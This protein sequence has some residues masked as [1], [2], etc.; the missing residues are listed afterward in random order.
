M[1]KSTLVL[2]LFCTP[3][4]ATPDWRYSLALADEALPKPEE[5]KAKLST[6]E[7]SFDSPFSNRYGSKEMRELFS[8]QTKHSTWRK[9]WVALAESEQE[10]GLPISNA[11]I[12]EM[13]A[14]IYTIDFALADKIEKDLK[15]DVMAHV[16]TYGVDCP[17]A[18]PIIHLGA[19]SCLITDNAE[20]IVMQDALTI[21]ERKL[22]TL[23]KTL[24]KQAD[25]YKDLP[26]LSYTH[27][28]AAQPTTVGKRYALWL[29]DFWLDW[30][31]LQYRQDTLRFLGVKGATGTQASFLELF[32]GNHE[33]VKALELLVAAKLGFS[34]IFAVSGQTY[35]RKQDIQ[36]LSI[37]SDIAVSAHKMA[38]DL[39]LLAHMKEIEEPFS[40]KQIGSSAMP[41]KRNPMENE[42]VCSL[43]RY[44]MALAENPKYTAAIQWL[45][46][47]LDDS[48]N[49]RLAIP[50]AF[51]AIDSILDSLIKIAGNSVVYPKIIEK[52]LQAELPFMA[53][54]N[55]LMACVKKGADRQAIHERLRQLSQLAGDQIKLEGKD[56]PL[57]EMIAN[58]PAIPLSEDE[59][60]E[61]ISDN[62]FIG[63][64]PQQVTEFL[65]EVVYPSLK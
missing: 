24:A 7:T 11:Q 14:H 22:L 18:R 62:C 65:D 41:Y 57:L 48:A 40:D 21:I 3:L 34:N 23:L 9:I 12:E 50:E 26:C 1:R 38:T 53:T 60:F 8:R 13:K 61:I 28:Q 58:D 6:S 39:R 64:A 4:L 63:R 25:S 42:R 55:I 31:D 51:L 46:R 30:Q 15:H 52:N 20:V 47:T 33:E 35:T 45:E 27:F 19:T 37:L 5:I 36:V 56:N 54:E 49:R 10:L 43:A 29:Q 16:K 32:D 59:L 17:L 44:V 2:T